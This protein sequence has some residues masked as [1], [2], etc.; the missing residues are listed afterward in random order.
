[1]R[2]AILA[3]G[4][5]NPDLGFAEGPANLD[6]A[7]RPTMARDDES[8]ETDEFDAFDAE[9]ARARACRILYGGFMEEE[10]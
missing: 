4:R 1:V 3:A 5:L 10:R 2:Q 8:E 7:G 6:F 9:R